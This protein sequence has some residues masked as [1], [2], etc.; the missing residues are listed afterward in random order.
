MEWN[1][2]LIARIGQR[3]AEDA[4]DAQ[5]KTSFTFDKR[6]YDLLLDVNIQ[7]LLKG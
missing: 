6:K 2:Y 7:Q 5:L 4:P 1:E 3:A